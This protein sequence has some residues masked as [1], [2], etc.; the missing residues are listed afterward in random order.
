MNNAMSTAVRGRTLLGVQVSLDRLALVGAAG[1][2]AGAVLVASS[3]HFLRPHAFGLFLANLIVGTFLI[4]F[5]WLRRRP[6]DPTG[7]LLLALG[8]ANLGLVLEGAS[9]PFLHTVGVL[10]ELLVVV[11]GFYVVFAFPEGRLTSRTDKIVMSV[12]LLAV[13]G[14]TFSTLLF[15]PAVS[16]RIHLGA[17]NTACPENPFM[18]ADRPAIA[19]ESGGSGSRLLA[20]IA[21]GIA[22]VLLVRLFNATPPRKR[23]L[24]PIYA[25]ALL[26]SLVIAATQAAGVDP[27]E[28]GSDTE[29]AL[30]WALVIA[31]STWAY[32]FLL[33]LV[34]TSVFAG[35]AL[36]QMVADLGPDASAAR[37]RSVV[38]GAVHDPSLELGFRIS[39]DPQ[40]DFVDSR[41][42][43][44]DLSHLGAGQTST[45]VQSAGR[46]VAVIVH[47]K[48]LN[49]DPEL[50]RSAGRVLLLARQ[51]DR[52]EQDLRQAV[53]RLRESRGRIATVRDTER[54]RIERD[55]HDG[56]QQRLVALR[57][58]L[59]LADE[60]VHDDPTRAAGLLREL[61][62]EAEEALSE[63][64]ALAH[65]IY[66]AVLVD[67]GL[68]DALRALARRMPI[69]TEVKP[70]A[71]AGTRRRSRVQPISAAS[72]QCRTS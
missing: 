49:R 24:A 56:A 53:R 40:S 9:S 4:A 68:G 45:P 39:G 20:A 8:F 48:A 61:G 58:G 65:G 32:G 11:L 12:V 33:A 37:L 34:L 7:R 16:S 51:N 2:A 64:R 46:T 14:R 29:R 31:R 22:G 69:V 13:L 23:M 66:P 19:S 38:A 52:L 67:Q 18:I 27:V 71:W 60:L 30:A 62:L 72:R 44:L 63:V 1:G 10:F 70:L 50:M 47:D 43:W 41:G 42:G 6:G 54:R 25:P 3:G 28:Q 26:L 17:C 55:L 15:A 57:I 59:G 5:Y 21:I 35:I 36:K